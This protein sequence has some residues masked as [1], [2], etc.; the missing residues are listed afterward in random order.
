MYEWFKSLTGAWGPPL[1]AWYLAN[2]WI[3]VPLIAYGVFLVLAWRNY[4]QIEQR[5]VDSWLAQSPKG[6]LPAEPETDWA[7]AVAGLRFPFVTR[8]G[9]LWLHRATPEKAEQ[10]LNLQAVRTRAQWRLD[11][12]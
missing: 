4:D 6:K 5:V 7:A 11:R 2:S 8:R 12:R 9:Y 3:N 10:V 1:L